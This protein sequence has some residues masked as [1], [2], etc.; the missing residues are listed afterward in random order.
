MRPVPVAQNQLSQ[1]FTICSRDDVQTPRLAAAVQDHGSASLLRLLDDAPRGG[2]AAAPGYV[3]LPDVERA[4][5]GDVGEA[6]V[7]EV[8]FAPGQ[9]DRLDLRPQFAA[10]PSRSSGVSVSSNQ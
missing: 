4:G 2:D 10:S 6:V 3:R 8:V 5:T 1:F 9:Q 7:G